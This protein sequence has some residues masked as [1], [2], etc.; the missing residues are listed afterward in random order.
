MVSPAG[1]VSVENLSTVKVSM[2]AD[3]SWKKQS[4]KI[5]IPITFGLSEDPGKQVSIAGSFSD[6]VPQAT[7]YNPL[8]MHYEY[9][10]DFDTDLLQ[11]SDDEED[12]V[13][14]YYKYIVDGVWKINE[15]VDS[16]TDEAGNINNVLCIS[17]A[18]DELTWDE[19]VIDPAA[20]QKSPKKSS[21]KALM[22]WIKSVF[23]FKNHHNHNK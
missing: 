17:A 22:L 1:I 13:V 14:I 2:P 9:V 16:T 12:K 5:I 10:Y 8:S 6:W 18:T 15:K 23:S 19:N 11:L 20:I 21:I 3:A 4:K 7:R